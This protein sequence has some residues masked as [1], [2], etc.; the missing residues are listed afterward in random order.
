MPLAIPL[1]HRLGCLH[2][3]HP[4]LL[5]R[6]SRWLLSL[7]PGRTRQLYSLDD[8]KE[9]GGAETAEGTSLSSVGSTETPTSISTEII[10]SSLSGME[11][12][13]WTGDK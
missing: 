12:E 9:E 3:P 7:A 4:T 6:P 5:I 2:T 13:V 8:G 10:I 1:T 11:R